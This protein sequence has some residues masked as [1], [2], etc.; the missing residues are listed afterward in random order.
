[1]LDEEEHEVVHPAR[2]AAHEE[3]V[4]VH[5]RTDLGGDDDRPGEDDHEQVVQP[6][7]RLQVLEEGHVVDV[8]REDERSRPVI[9]SVLLEG[10]KRV[11]GHEGE[12]GEAEERDP[13][14]RDHM[15]REPAR[16]C[17]PR[18]DKVAAGQC[19]HAE[20]ARAGGDA[21]HLEV[22]PL[23][24]V[25]PAHRQ[26]PRERRRGARLA[27]A[28]EALCSSIHAVAERE[29]RAEP[30]E[31]KRDDHAEVRLHGP[32][33]Y[34]VSVGDDRRRHASRLDGIATARGAGH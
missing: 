14:I 17:V 19:N 12:V 9:E 26:E 6:V 20:N 5:H 4:V 8:H 21:G 31:R 2:H 3:V 23:L 27:L 22:G 10:G 15:Q 29:Q 32:G 30:A 24:A 33:G 13:H 16:L 18:V 28:R 1:V 34:P 25:Q 7:D 11:G